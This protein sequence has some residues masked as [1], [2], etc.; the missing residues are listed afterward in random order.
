MYYAHIDGGVLCNAACVINV[1]V[2]LH[3]LW[4]I[5]MYYVWFLCY[6]VVYY[7]WLMVFIYVYYG[8]FA[9]TILVDVM[10]LFSWFFR[11]I[12]RISAKFGRFSVKPARNS[13]RRFLEKPADLS[14]KSADLLVK[15]GV[16]R[17]SRFS[18]FLRHLRCILT[19]FSRILS[20]FSKT[21][22]IGEVRFSLLSRIP[23]SQTLCYSTAYLPEPRLK[24]CC[25]AIWNPKQ[26]HRG[27]G[28][29]KK[30]KIGEKEINCLFFINCV[31]KIIVIKLLLG[32]WHRITK[33]GMKYDACWYRNERE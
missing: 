2:Y 23:G 12:Y 31:L 26:D 24:L 22:V 21:D 33:N 6:W 14:V 18:L 29:G 30:K 9:C 5:F 4:I 13:P 28:Q 11:S 20:N 7:V 16:F 32:N 3:V 8:L 17:C 1:V 15:P 27:K 19:D 25:S 10:S